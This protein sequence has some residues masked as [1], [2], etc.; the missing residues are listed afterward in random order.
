MSEPPYSNE[1]LQF[2]RLVVSAE[3]FLQQKEDTSLFE[4]IT[5]PSKMYGHILGLP[6]RDTTCLYLCGRH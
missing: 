1:M 3:L 6:F 4:N 5:S 2:G